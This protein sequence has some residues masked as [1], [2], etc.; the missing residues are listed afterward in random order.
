MNQNQY[1]NKK[2]TYTHVAPE[3]LLGMISDGSIPDG[4]A[5]ERIVREYVAKGCPAGDPIYLSVGETWTEI[6]PGLLA[7]AVKPWPAALNGYLLSQ[8]GLPRLQKVLRK[9]IPR[10]HQLPADF[11]AGRDF[12]VAVASHGTRTYMFDFGRMLQAKATLFSKTPVVV[13][14]LPGWDYTGV[15]SN[16]GFKMQYLPLRRENQF[17]PHSNDIEQNLKE[18][19]SHPGEYLALVVINAQHNPTGVNWSEREVRLLIKLALERNA[20]ILIDDA[21]YAISDPKV[22]ATSS[23]KILAEELQALSKEARD[24]V[25]WLAVRSLGKQFHCNGWGIGVA[26]SSPG[27]LHQVIIRHL[28]NRTYTYSGILQNAMATWLESPESDAYLEMKRHDFLDKKETIVHDLETLLHYPK[29]SF[30]KG[31]CGSYVLFEIPPYALV[32]KTAQAEEEFRAALFFKTG[33]LLGPGSMVQDPMLYRFN[34]PHFR[35][36]LGP[37]K[38]AI[39]AA[40]ERLQAAGFLWR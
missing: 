31:D 38:E 14:P 12:E 13:A 15:F 36:F 29:E 25:A 30:Y 5:D 4:L 3:S 19:D 16:L 8:Y 2:N 17:H 26:T 21:Y 1:Q 35:V 37:K 28:F 24:S 11:E 9:Y 40:F 23:L 20:A 39:H 33:V 7:E 10:T 22:K 27:C 34:K 18:I 32:N 6:A